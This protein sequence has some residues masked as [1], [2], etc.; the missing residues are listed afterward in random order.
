MLSKLT[1]LK[2]DIFYVQL[3]KNKF[4]VRNMVTD[5]EMS[6]ARE[7]A[8]LSPRMILPNVN[9]AHQQLTPLFALLATS[10][11]P[12]YCLF[13]PRQLIEGGIT[14]VERD[15]FSELGH[16][17]LGKKGHIMLSDSP[18]DLTKAQLLLATLSFA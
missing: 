7:A 17:L 18:T 15:A 13:H 2:P 9:L 16:R 3:Y 4:I 14:T 5:K 10:Y 12:A 11:R 1:N 8:G 6:M